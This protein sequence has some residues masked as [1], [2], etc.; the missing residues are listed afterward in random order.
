MRGRWGGMGEKGERIKKY[1]L[2][3]INVVTGI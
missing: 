2:P 3:V 1:K